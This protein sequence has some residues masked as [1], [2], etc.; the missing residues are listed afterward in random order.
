[1][2]PSLVMRPEQERKKAKRPTVD[3]QLEDDTPQQSLADTLPLSFKI[4]T[5]DTQERS[6]LPE[7]CI[8]ERRATSA[9]EG[10]ITR[11][12]VEQELKRAKKYKVYPSTT[13]EAV[14][15]WIVDAAS[16]VFAITVQCHLT[17]D[18]LLSSMLNFYNVAFEDDDLPIYDPRAP[19]HNSP[20]PQRSEAF[21]A[22]IWEDL[23]HD[24]FFQ[25]QWRCLAPVFTPEKYEY[26]L[27]SQC[28]LPFRKDT[29]V[30]PRTGS[31]SSVYKVA[32]HPDHQKRHKSHEVAIKEISVQKSAGLLQ[33]GKEQ[34]EK[35]WDVES[36][37][38][39]SINL[40]DHDHIIKS[41]AAIRRGEGRYF[42]FPWAHDSLRD[43]W[44][45]TP[46]QSPTSELILEAILQLRGI[47]DAL[48]SLHNFRGIRSST[49]ATH[50]D[51]P[52]VVN[53]ADNLA[54]QTEDDEVVSEYSSA[55][56]QESI[57][58][59]D[60][61][62]ENILRFLDGNSQIGT[63]K[64]GDMGLAK[65]HVAATVKR[66]G[67]SMRFS[68]RRYEGP[69]AVRNKEGRSRLYDLWSMGCITFEFILWLLYGNN[70]LVE[71]NKQA[72]SM[73]PPTEEFQYYKVQGT[74]QEQRAIIHPLAE[75]WMDYLQERDPEFQSG[76][77][78]ALK[79]LLRIVRDHLLVVELPPTRGS[80]LADGGGARPL[81]PPVFVGQR[82]KYRATAAEFRKALDAI[83]GKANDVHYLYTGI[84]RSDFSPPAPPSTFGTFLNPSAQRLS[85]P[86][87]RLDTKIEPITTGVMQR[88][89][90]A[91]YSL[92]PLESWNFE[93]DNDF[94]VKVTKYI[95][96]DSHPASS[97]ATTN[98][99]RRCIDLNFWSSGFAIEDDVTELAKSA[100]LCDFCR[101]LHQVSSD[102]DRPQSEKVRFERSQSVITVT[103]SSFPVLSIFRSQGLATP[104]AIQIGR[105]ELSDVESSSSNGFFDLAKE[106]LKD[107]DEGHDGCQVHIS[108]KLPTR[109]MDVGTT[110]DPALRL[111]ETQ[112]EV[113]HNTRYIALSHP[114]G[115]T[116]A[117][118]TFVTLSKDESDTGHDIA[119]FK[120]SI[121]YGDLPRTFR[122]AV[123]CTRNLNIR[124]LWIDSICI[125]QG[126][127]GDFPE[128]AKR[129]EDVYSGAYC[130][131]AASR[132][133]DQ[134]NGFLGPRPQRQYVKFQPERPFYVCRTIDHFNEDV[135]MGS[136]NQ[137]GWVLQERA[138][139]RRTMYFTENQT[140]FEC[141]EGVRCET[142]T[143]MHNNREE[144]LGDPSFPDKAMRSKSRALKIE[145]FQG[146]YK[147]YSRLGFTRWEDRPVAIAGLEKRL[148]K[149][150]NTKGRYGIFDDGDT[151][152][153]GLFHRSLLWRRSWEEAE[154]KN[155]RPLEAIVFPAERNTH[156]PSWSWMAYRGDI[157]YTDP[158]YQ[159]ATW[160]TRELIPP[161]TRGNQDPDANEDVAIAAVAR[162][163][164]LKGRNPDE[165]KIA[166]DTERASE[167][168]RVQCV[169]VA[170]SNEARS[171]RERWFYILLVIP[172][173]D[174][175]TEGKPARYKRV[176]AGLM[177]GK[178]ITL[179]KDGTE[180]RIF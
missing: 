24:E 92:P 65:R 40:L 148:Q 99:C 87:R 161:W 107:C 111:V 93:V 9:V 29:K 156:V 66:L 84:T 155:G 177:L 46:T 3:I 142:L 179:D 26:D 43:Y 157:D 175:A 69:E 76:S 32:V 132:A 153:G 159:S 38:L 101:L 81:A 63:L 48:D 79:D 21:N 162:D 147:Q 160:E 11:S 18:K 45:T 165:V 80:A 10:L 102:I 67:T 91:D 110:S 123:D 128:E 178:Y 64:L 154:K 37:A 13:L 146:L 30:D 105:P 97:A 133:N 95:G 116:A 25:F 100:A 118:Q 180:V 109:L 127:D 22:K 168:Q 130:V 41:I 12:T 2:P 138:L 6:Y 31:F 77:Q 74:G 56:S 44:N 49:D 94:A 172:T 152:D 52:V 14:I 126:P 137:R 114:W 171:D 23:R 166:Y 174:K 42:V 8:K 7:P 17:P 88:S 151:A 149:A 83:K 15:D 145:Y 136:L 61:K 5:F 75:R 140:Y 113:V 82:T 1:M 125:I 119:R 60:L 50:R 39:N 86:S 54:S 89:I 173:K 98:L 62:P 57:R 34:T 55:M 53:A 141:G 134:R 103:G 90:K 51:V 115:D 135:I 120:L 16:K 158:P 164:D 96:V 112:H 73:T 108:H 144:F 170:R 20:R 36:R 19:D 122:D 71:F 176:G 104:I 4:S 27:P 106:W 78:S 121:P 143:R 47:A 72:E 169:T 124:Y 139:A 131:I 68:T 33:T 58:H 150:F 167:G 85:S 28:I 163:F 129:M 70:A 117:Y 59:G 35:A